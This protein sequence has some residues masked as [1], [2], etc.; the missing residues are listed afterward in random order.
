VQPIA[1]TLFYMNS[2]KN[3]FKAKLKLK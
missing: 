2:F 1:Q 3:Q